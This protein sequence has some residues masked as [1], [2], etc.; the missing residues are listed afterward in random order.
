[1]NL[2]RF[3]K[4]F[5]S[6]FFLTQYFRDEHRLMYKKSTTFVYIFVSNCIF[7]RINPSRKALG[8]WKLTYFITWTI[9]FKSPIPA[10][11]TLKS[12]PHLPKKVLLFAS[13]TAL[14]KMMKNPFCF[15]LKDLFVLKIFKFLSWIFGH[16]DETARLER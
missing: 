5:D 16:V 10:A 13:M 1:M 9:L 12:D 8:S 7:F 15:I 6:F 11:A 3:I 14:Q 4:I 2:S